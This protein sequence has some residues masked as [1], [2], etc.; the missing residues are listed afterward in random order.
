MVGST[1]HQTASWVSYFNRGSPVKVRKNFALSKFRAVEH[2]RFLV[3][4]GN[5]GMS[6]LIDPAGR[7]IRQSPSYVAA[8]VVGEVAWMRGSTLYESNGDAPWWMSALAI[9]AILAM[10]AVP[11]A[12]LRRG[13]RPHGWPAPMTAPRR[14]AFEGLIHL[15]PRRR[16]SSSRQNQGESSS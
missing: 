16:G 6:A 8:T 10:R 14:E 5:T 4:A 12:S 9:L 1:T 13:R 7:V 15:D 3:R 11:A 2:R